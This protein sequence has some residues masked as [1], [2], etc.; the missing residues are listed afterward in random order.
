MFF[1]TGLLM[2]LPQLEGKAAAGF[3]GALRAALPSSCGSATE[4][5]WR[6]R[7]GSPPRARAC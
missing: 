4:L 1:R 3:A 6:V 2:A 7:R 5:L